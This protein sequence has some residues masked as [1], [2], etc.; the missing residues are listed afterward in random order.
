MRIHVAAAAA[1]AQWW[2]LAV[3]LR[4]ASAAIEEARIHE[5]AAAGA[6][7]S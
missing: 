4:E 7:E 2:Q 3:L 1:G 5:A 6:H